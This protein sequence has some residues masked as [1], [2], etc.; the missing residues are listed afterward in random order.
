M[1]RVLSEAIAGPARPSGRASRDDVR[2]DE[3]DRDQRQEGRPDDPARREGHRGRGRGGHRPGVVAVAVAGRAGPGL[4]PGQERLAL[5]A[6]DDAGADEREGGRHDQAAP[7]RRA[8]RGQ[9]AGRLGR[10][11]EGRDGEGP[12]AEEERRD[13]E[14]GHGRPAE[15]A[16]GRL[17]VV[18]RH[19]EVDRRDEE[20]HAE[21]APAGR[22]RRAAVDALAPGEEPEADDV[23]GHGHVERRARR[24]EAGRVQP[25]DARG[26]E[27]QGHGQHG[28]VRAADHAPGEGREEEGRLDRAAPERLGRGLEGRPA[29]GQVDGQHEPERVGQRPVAGGDEAVDDR[30]PRQSDLPGGEPED[31]LVAAEEPRQ[32]AGEGPER[33][34]RPGRPALEVGQPLGGQ[35]AGRPQE[36]RQDGASHDHGR[37]GHEEQR[38]VVGPGRG[39]GVVPRHA[40]EDRGQRPQVGP[41]LARRPVSDRADQGGEGQAARQG[42]LAGGQPRVGREALR[43]REEVGHHGPARRAPQVSAS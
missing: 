12:L 41:A 28:R 26:G 22:G 34:E 1:A 23:E 18:P 39:A 8:G 15:E 7:P 9:R 25:V 10:E 5:Q 2:E 35:R 13:E 11:E 4:E 16:R 30:G 24:E 17:G 21:E 31:R 3:P 33:G 29:R 19:L 20:E 14:P 40:E 32:A 43:Q 27:G 36:P 37:P 6:H 38:A 42:R